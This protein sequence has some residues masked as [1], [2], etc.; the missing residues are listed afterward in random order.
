MRFVDEGAEVGDLAV[1]GMYVVVVGDVVAVVA[2]R[3]R[4]ERQ[5]PQRV[6]AEFLQVVEP[7]DQ[8]RKVAHAVAVAVAEGLDVQ[9][10]DDGVLV[11]VRV[12]FFHGQGV[13]RCG[14]GSFP[15]PGRG[16][17]S[18]RIDAIARRAWYATD[19]ARQRHWH[20]RRSPLRFLENSG[21]DS[22][23]NQDADLQGVGCENAA[24]TRHRSAVWREE[25]R[26]WEEG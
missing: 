16:W 12:F 1:S 3:R 26:A 13:P 25:I 5:Q 14:T 23:S 6:H 7:R 24:N 22:R 21:R 11:P 20:V 8:P 9:L 19:E 2:H 17:L 15:F 10:V 18:F 4:V